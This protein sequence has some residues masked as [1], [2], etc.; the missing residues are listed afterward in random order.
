MTEQNFQRQGN[1]IYT[2]VTI[3]FTEAIL[4]T[5]VNIK[6]LSKTVSLSVP[7][8]TQPGAILRLNGQGLAVDGTSGDL[9]VEIKVSLPKTLTDEQRKMI[10]EWGE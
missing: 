8:G 3:P 9:F 6:T 1:D 4:G 7:A 2:S 5:K 10:E